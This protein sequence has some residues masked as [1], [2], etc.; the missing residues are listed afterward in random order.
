M[1]AHKVAHQYFGDLIRIAKFEDTW[2]E[3]A[4]TEYISAFW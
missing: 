1:F 3:E 4:P 2:L